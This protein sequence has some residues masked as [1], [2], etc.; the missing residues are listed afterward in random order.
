MKALIRQW[1]G[2]DH[3]VITEREEFKSYLHERLS[4]IESYIE[5]YVDL[6]IKEELDDIK[7]NY[8]NLESQMDN[9]ENCEDNWEFQNMQQQVSANEDAISNLEE[10]ITKLDNTVEDFKAVMENYHDF[11]NA[12]EERI[13]MI[14]NDQVK[15]LIEKLN[16]ITNDK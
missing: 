14:L 11:H 15:N 3:M 7:D 13:N 5:N 8:D 12:V 9:F 2:I 10:T 6:T 4:K 16:A 1:L